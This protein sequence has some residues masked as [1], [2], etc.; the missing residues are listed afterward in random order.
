VHAFGLL[1]CD[2]MLQG[3]DYGVCARQGQLRSRLEC[4]REEP[5]GI[6]ISIGSSPGA[7]LYSPDRCPQLV[8]FDAHARVGLPKAAI[9]SR[10][11]VLSGASASSPLCVDRRKKVSHFFDPGQPPQPLQRLAWGGV[12]VPRHNGTYRILKPNPCTAGQTASSMWVGLLALTATLSSRASA[13]R[14]AGEW[15]G[16]MK[17]STMMD[18]H[19]GRSNKGCPM[20]HAATQ[21]PRSC[22]FLAPWVGA[23]REAMRK[24][25]VKAF[26]AR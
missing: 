21:S 20:L 10:T 7:S 19:V 22:A 9:T 8:R 13:S 26:Q 23:R 11:S 15:R 6:V 24:P 25:S 2:L 17:M 4:L 5:G 3:L 16:A 12:S 18:L 1:M 14:S